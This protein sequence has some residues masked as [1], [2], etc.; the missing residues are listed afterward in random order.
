MDYTIVDVERPREIINTVKGA[1]TLP[2]LESLISVHDKPWMRVV[3]IGCHINLSYELC[4]YVMVDTEW[5]MGRPREK[6]HKTENGL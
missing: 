1:E 6:R 5:E 2:C 3:R 4:W